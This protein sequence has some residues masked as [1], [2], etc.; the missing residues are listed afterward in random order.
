MAVH[1]GGRCRIRGDWDGA[2]ADNGQRQSDSVRD[3]S[4]I[5]TAVS[6]ESSLIKHVVSLESSLIKYVGWSPDATDLWY[7]TCA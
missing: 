4:L 5:K 7:N 2:V 6:T 1:R 3:L